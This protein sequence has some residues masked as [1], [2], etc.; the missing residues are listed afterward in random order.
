MTLIHFGPAETVE[1]AIEQLSIL[2][3]E[4]SL[5]VFCGSGISINPPSNLPSGT[6]LRKMILDSILDIDIDENTREILEK[7]YLQ[8][9]KNEREE[10]DK[11]YPFEKYI[12]TID[13]STPIVD[14]L[15]KLFKTGKP[16]KNHALIAELIKLGYIKKVMTTNFDTKIEEALESVLTPISTSF[17]KDRDY[18]LY[19]NELQFRDLDF[20]IF[21]N[22]TIFKIHGTIE[23]LSSI[24]ATLDVV[25]SRVLRESRNR[26]LRDFFQDAEQDILVMGYSGSDEFDINPIIRNCISKNKIFF[27]KHSRRDSLNKPFISSLIYPFNNFKG[28]T[29]HIN[30]DDLID[31]IWNRF[32]KSE[33]NDDEFNESWRQVIRDWSRSL[34]DHEK[35]FTSGNIL[36]D[37]NENS[38]AKFLFKRS[39]KI[40]NRLTD[41]LGKAD[42]LGQ[43]ATI[44][45]KKGNF[46][47]ALDLHNQSFDLMKL[48]GNQRGIATSL[49]QMASIH[50][51][52]GN[53]NK[54]EDLNRLNLE[55]WEKLKDQSGTALS[56]HQRAVIHQAKGEY[57][58]AIELFEKS[59][60]L[61]EMIGDQSGVAVCLSQMAMIYQDQG[62]YN[63]A[64]ELTKKSMG[65]KEMMGDDFGIAASLHKLA[66]IY[67][68][69]HEDSEA[70]QL[71]TRSLKIRKRLKD[72]L[73][74][75]ESLAQIAM[76]HMNRSEFE[77]AER[78]NERSLKIYNRLKDQQGM[79][80][81]LHQKAVIHQA[82]GE[83]DKAIELFQRSIK[84]KEIIGD[85][86]G[87]ARS[88]ALMA[89]INHVRGQYA[90]AENLCNKALDI[91]TTLN[92]KPGMA[93]TLGQMSRI[94]EDLCDYEKAGELCKKSLDIFIML[95]DQSG[96]SRCRSIL[97]RL[98]AKNG[99]KRDKEVNL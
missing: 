49:Y 62:D 72:K 98:S 59:L 9:K 17:K 16:N 76:I 42:S 13:Q 23:D 55:I 52:M 85:R 56:I 78:F 3:K 7:G 64:E 40:S 20:A 73:G 47:I 6:L 50:I 89:I 70:K 30:T 91:Y 44:E 27:I 67:F 77:K 83:H 90:E 38:F 80:W 97:F 31:F 4:K 24:R 39:L 48:L 84:L 96:I 1:H 14:S 94:Y 82:K 99:K 54:A 65:I 10:Y 87:I 2:I 36:L 5:A 81:S 69:K 57:D 92:V 18:K 58:K 86:L 61:N 19:Y 53:Y 71:Y 26:V 25:S 93:A 88:V 29:L 41:Q 75:A 15:A 74:I 35:C 46:D 33:W 34:K 43:L 8:R 66:G 11:F 95:G 28:N 68:L 60:N 37:V 21:K 12:Q 79:A 22:P 45:Q 51:L 63:K 32:I